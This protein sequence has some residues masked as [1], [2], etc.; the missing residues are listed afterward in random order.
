MSKD[1]YYDERI[2]YEAM[3]EREDEEREHEEEYDEFRD[4][5]FA[6]EQDYL[7]WKYG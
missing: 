4:N 1:E 7:S 5:G 6:N 3:C 2:A